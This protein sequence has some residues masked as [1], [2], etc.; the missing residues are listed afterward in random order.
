MNGG[1]LGRFVFGGMVG[2]VLHVLLLAGIV[3]AAGVA[4][5]A[6]S[7]GKAG[8]LAAFALILAVLTSPGGFVLGGVAALLAAG[9]RRSAL[10]VAGVGAG[11]G[12]GIGLVVLAGLLALDRSNVVVG[13]ALLALL[14][15]IGF[16]IAGAVARW[17]APRAG[18]L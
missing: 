11:T 10:A 12:G 1:R 7:A 16:A 17:S 4:T 13:L 14:A 3:T 6:R 15:A 18:R 2:A 5:E 9:G 8:E